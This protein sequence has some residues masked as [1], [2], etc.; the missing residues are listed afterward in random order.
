MEAS[1]QS[2]AGGYFQGVKVNL[3]L[4]TGNLSF[5]LEGDKNDANFLLHLKRIK[6]KFS[7]IMEL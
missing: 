1:N 6:D 3:W 7:H 2:P 4:P 5:F